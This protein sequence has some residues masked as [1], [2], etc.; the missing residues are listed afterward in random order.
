MKAHYSVSRFVWPI[1]FLFFLLYSFS[2]CSRKSEIGR[3]VLYESFPQTISLTA[4]QILLDEENVLL[5]YPY[6]VRVNEKRTHAVVLD[7]H[8]DSCF[9]HLFTYPD[10]RFLCSFGKHGEGADEYLSGDDV[11]WCDSLLWTVDSNRKLWKAYVVKGHEVKLVRTVD[12]SVTLR[13]LDFA[14]ICDTLAYIPDYT[15]ECRMLR[16]DTCGK[17]RGKLGCIPIVEHVSAPASSQAQA[18]RSFPS[19]NSRNGVLAVA[20]QLGEVLEI[21]HSG[22]TMPAAVLQ[23][24]NGEP[25][26]KVSGGHGIP[27]GIMGFNDVQMTDSCIYA[28]FQGTPFEE[29]GRVINKGGKP[30]DGGR[31]IYVFSLSGNPLRCYELD[32]PVSGIY[33]DE[34]RR[35]IVALNVNDSFQMMTF[36]F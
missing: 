2:S 25:R 18:W 34:K 21:Y 31:F 14:F 7:L 10:F 22:D 23:G 33:V 15:G 17:I 4:E 3:R 35:S 27:V 5:C 30:V 1:L 11:H 20:T 19:Y 29:I 36:D 16:V 26:F 8:P 12:L 28:V 9:F 32:Y 6:R 24:P 13:P